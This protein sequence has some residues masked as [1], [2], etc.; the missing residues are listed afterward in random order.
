M[1]NNNNR[2]SQHAYFYFD[3]IETKQKVLNII[4]RD[5]LAREKL[6]LAAVDGQYKYDY[7][8]GLVKV[9]LSGS[10]TKSKGPDEGCYFRRPRCGKRLLGRRRDIDP[11]GIQQ[12]EI[13]W[14]GDESNQVERNEY[15]RLINDNLIISCIYQGGKPCNPE[16][17]TNSEQTREKINSSQIV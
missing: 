11:N 4:N 17:D 13:F 2:P 6:I 10:L 1:E 14:V 8:N 9:A 3:N 15:L 16:G 5:K 12:I 7:G